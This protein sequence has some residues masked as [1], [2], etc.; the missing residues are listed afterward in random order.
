MPGWPGGCHR[1]SE[2]FTHCWTITQ[3]GVG[4]IVRDRPPGRG[5]DVRGVPSPANRQH[6]TSLLTTDYVK[7]TSQLT[8][9]EQVTLGHVTQCYQQIP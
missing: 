5:R 6:D 4:S 8:S 7:R 9:S 3:A 1:L 2:H